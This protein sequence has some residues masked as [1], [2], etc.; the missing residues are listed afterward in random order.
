MRK[1]IP[2]AIQLIKIT[3][4]PMNQ[5]KSLYSVP[6]L[7]ILIGLVLV[8]GC[9]LL[10]LW[11]LS[12]GEIVSIGN[13]NVP[14]G[15][16]NNLQ[17]QSR[18]KAVLVVVL[19]MCLWW[20]S[21]LMAFAEFVMGGVIGSW[22]FTKEKSTIF[23]PV[24]KSVHNCLR[25][26]L[27]SVVRGGF[28]NLFFAL[29]N[30]FLG[31]ICEILKK[32]SKNCCF[33]TAAYCCCPCLSL[34]QRSTKYNTKHSY[35]YLSIFA[36]PY[37]LSSKQC[38]FLMQRNSQ[39]IKSPLKSLNYLIFQV[40][41]SICLMGL[42]ASYI[43]LTF[44]PTTLLNFPTT[45]LSSTLA[46]SL[47][48]FTVCIFLSEIVGGCMSACVNSFAICSILNEEMF[49]AEQRFINT[50]MQIILD[51]ASSETRNNDLNPKIVQKP[52]RSNR[53]PMN[54]IEFDKDFQVKVTPLKADK[55]M[56]IEEI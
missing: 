10:V 14:G 41:L 45:D 17:F 30:F 5:I 23:S 44:S 9:F 27:G 18:D 56:R 33:L 1:N 38:Y 29:P 13:N 47:F 51:Q 26:H 11:T 40:K 55:K 20:M 52:G 15:A 32:H 8:A 19:M 43:F 34:Y 46:P 2:N 16:I 42:F 21:A 3:A 48:T 49:T 22:F 12:I 53:V 25:F 7:L 54:L 36:L 39:R 35:I 28:Y 50:E 24:S 37:D 4:E 6:I 31:G